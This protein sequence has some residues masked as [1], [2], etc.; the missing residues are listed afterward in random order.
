MLWTHAVSDIVIGLSYFSIP[1]AM[2]AFLA[3]RPDLPF[4]RIYW[5]FVAFILAC[6][7]THLL[8]V[9]T[10]WVPDYAVAALAKAVTAGTSVFTAATLWWLLPE[11]ATLPTPS[12]LREVSRERD[13][14]ETANAQSSAFLARVSG[15]IRTPLSS[16]LG[17]TDLLLGESDLRP[18]DRRR[19]DIIQE[20]G[21]S[22]LAVAETI[23]DFSRHGGEGGE[24]FDLRGL[25]M[26]AAAVARSAAAGRGTAISVAID[27]GVPERV[28]GDAD[29]LRRVVLALLAEAA[30]P[31]GPVALALRG[32]GEGGVLALTVAGPEE[33]FAEAPA[34]GAAR[35]GPEQGLALCRRLLARMGGD[36]AVARRPGEGATARVR[37]ALE[38]A[39]RPV[40][41]PA[42]RRGAASEAF[43]TAP[44][45]LLVEDAPENQELVRLMLEEEGYA[46]EAASDGA[47]AVARIRAA[48]YRLVLMDVGMPT[49]DGITATRR[50]RELAGPS[51]RVPIV[52]MTG[53]VLPQHLDA[54]REAGMDDVIAKPFKRTELLAVIAHWTRL[55]SAAG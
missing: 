23:V 28:R 10:L 14:A 32:A 19:L 51:G 13:A 47:A 3:R 49:M 25:V 2:A 48:P 40:R 17:F 15:E 9:W 26:A 37:L 11:A 18:E 7:T 20:S 24:P 12:Q 30:A 4:R 43:P 46:V 33:A 50:I 6:G 31:G 29:A 42:P 41:D 1:L 35:T 55:E 21:S 45:I 34:E 38:A 44:R 54:C 22:L 52:A 27:E 5:G 53:N 8:D 16:I 39:P 36:I